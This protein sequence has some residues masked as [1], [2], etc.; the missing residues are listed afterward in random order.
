[1]LPLGFNPIELRALEARVVPNPLTPPVMTIA[2]G[3]SSRYR[4]AVGG[5][6]VGRAG[7]RLGDD[8][9]SW[10]GR[11]RDL[12][13]QALGVLRLTPLPECGPRS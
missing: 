10:A 1:M 12:G 4:W 13:R 2:S 7:A 9:A 5:L 3:M 8:P 11:S 6:R